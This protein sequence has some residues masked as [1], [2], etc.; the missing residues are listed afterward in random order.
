VTMNILYNLRLHYGTIDGDQKKYEHSR[1]LYTEYQQI[2]MMENEAE[3]LYTRF[4]NQYVNSRATKEELT[5]EAEEFYE[6]IRPN[7]DK[8]DSFRLH[9]CG[10]LLELMVH[11]SRNDYVKS[12]DACRSAIEFF[13]NKPYNSSLPMQAFY[14]QLVVCHVQL[15]EFEKGADII[16]RYQDIYEDG[17]FNWFKL[18]ELFFLLAMHTGHYQEAFDVYEKVAQ[19][20]KLSTQPAGIQET[21][22]IL[23]AYAHFLV[24][25]GKVER[26]PTTRFR[27][28]K[29]LNE[30]PKFSQDKRGMNIP[31]LVAQVLFMFADKQ[32]AHT[33]DRIEALDRYCS[34]YLKK[35]DTF[36]SNCFIKM[37]LAI[38]EAGFHREAV[39]R[40]AQ[41]FREL[42]DS[43]PMELSNQAHG[44]EIIPYEAL[45]EM[46]LEMLDNQIIIPRKK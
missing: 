45:W 11:S 29:F 46:A 26:E 19:H 38:P 14:Y 4:V 40:K 42:L 6:R 17:S 10:R 25:N 12:A 2:W 9:L 15:K 31:V 43:M 37:L 18:Q 1:T 5:G 34:R 33:I 16:R 13:E 24:H 41:K 8:C 36:R 28:S 7:L 27:L 30:I 39:V 23:E 20:N 3:E 35:N 22:K 32:F 44:I 21:W